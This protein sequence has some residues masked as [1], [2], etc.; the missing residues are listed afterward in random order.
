MGLIMKQ[1]NDGARIPPGEKLRFRI[2]EATRDDG[3]YG[4]QVKLVLEVLD[5][6]KFKGETIFEWAKLAQPRT[7]FVRNLRGKGYKDEKI[8]EI[9]RQEDYK[10]N[11]IDEA[12]ETVKV[13]Q[14]GKLIN[15]AMAC[16]QGDLTAVDSLGSIEDLLL[17]LKD[18]TFV[19]IVKARGADGKYIGITW[20]MV[21]TDPEASGAESDLDE[22]FDDLDFGDDPP[23]AF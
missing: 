11:K 15:I 8:A 9:L 21:Y 1:K 6:S 19:S 2:N 13:G 3:D 17:D 10:F 23:P 22:D 5:G 16:F 20:D 18:K 12:E 4:P 14:A 7:D